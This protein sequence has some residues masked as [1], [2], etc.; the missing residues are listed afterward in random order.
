M[1]LKIVPA[2][3]R[4]PPWSY[5]ETTSHASVAPHWITLFAA[6]AV[7]LLTL[8]PATA[9]QANQPGFD[10]RQAE[11]HFDNQQSGQNFPTRPA[12]RMPQLVRPG[13]AGDNRPQFVLNGVYLT[14]ASALPRDH[15]AA[16]YQPYLGKK[17]SQADLA[18]IAQAIS[19]LYR[20]AGFQLS[21]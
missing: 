8:A 20:A 16:A 19:D 18:A 2:F 1:W 14:G 13:V 21:R 7:S 9:Q 17:V 6:V 10:P 11:K 12:L 5:G 15:L 3:T 4:C